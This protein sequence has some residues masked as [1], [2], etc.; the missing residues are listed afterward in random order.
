MEYLNGKKLNGTGYD[1]DKEII[2]ELKD[3]N[4]YIK[5][6]NTKYNELSLEG[7]FLNGEKKSEKENNIIMSMV[8]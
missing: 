8:H 2:Y 5:E 7:E 4:R 3:V 6:Y 1:K